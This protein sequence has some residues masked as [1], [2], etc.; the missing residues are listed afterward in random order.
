[1]ANIIIVQKVRGRETITA[2]QSLRSGKV[3]HASTGIGPTGAALGLIEAIS[4]CK[5]KG[6]TICTP[7][8]KRVNI[9]KAA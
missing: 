1:M 5:R 2:V 4:Y 9:R 3:F 8:G 6:H 7:E